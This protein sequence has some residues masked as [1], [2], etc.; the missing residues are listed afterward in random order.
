[1]LTKLFIGG[2]IPTCPYVFSGSFDDE[3]GV[4]TEQSISI[5]KD[6]GGAV[7]LTQEGR[8]IVIAEHDF[9]D[10]VKSLGRVLKEWE[11]SEGGKW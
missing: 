9:K 4:A 3:A 11:A 7:V 1:M 6:A 5:W 10:F 8:D 2:K